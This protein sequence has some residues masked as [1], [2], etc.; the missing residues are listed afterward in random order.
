M[1]IRKKTAA[2]CV[3]GPEDKTIELLMQNKSI[4]YK[5]LVSNEPPLQA[6]KQRSELIFKSQKLSESHKAD[7]SRKHPVVLTGT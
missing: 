1:K 2:G 6:R 7:R 5:E 4:V 3:A